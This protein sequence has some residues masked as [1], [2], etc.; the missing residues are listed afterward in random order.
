M[1][2]GLYFSLIPAQCLYVYKYILYLPWPEIFYHRDGCVRHVNKFWEELIVTASLK[3]FLFILYEAINCNKFVMILYWLLWCMLLKI[4]WMQRV[5]PFFFFRRLRVA[6]WVNHIQI[7]VLQ[8]YLWVESSVITFLSSNQ[9]NPV[10]DSGNYVIPPELILKIIYTFPHSEFF[11]Y[12]NGQN[13]EF[14]S[15]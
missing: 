12:F 8:K 11:F 7:H 4:I 5:C 15:T 13:Q 1:Y 9:V 3:M 14:L 2:S 10:K 6:S